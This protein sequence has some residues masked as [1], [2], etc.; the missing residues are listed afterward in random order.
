MRLSFKFRIIASLS[1]MMLLAVGSSAIGYYGVSR[2]SDSSTKLASSAME[3]LRLSVEI[4]AHISEVEGQVQV[5]LDDGTAFSDSNRTAAAFDSVDEGLRE[6]ETSHRQLREVLSE[7]Y[8]QLDAVFARNWAEII[9]FERSLREAARSRSNLAGQRLFSTEGKEAYDAVSSQLT[10]TAQTAVEMNAT[11]EMMVALALASSNLSGIR[12]A[13][14]A[15]SLSVDDAEIE[16]YALQI[17]ALRAEFMSQ[18]TTAKSEAVATTMAAIDAIEPLW[19][20]YVDVVEQ[21]T[22]ALKTNDK[23]QVLAMLGKKSEL[24]SAAHRAMSSIIDRSEVDF[25]KSLEASERGS[26]AAERTMLGTAIAALLAGLLLA[27][28][29]ARSLSLGLSKAVEVARVVSAGQ[30]DIDPSTSR[31]DEIGTLLNSLAKMVENLRRN[32]NVIGAISG[33]NLQVEFKAVSAEDQV[34]SSVERMVAQLQ[35]VIGRV[36]GDSESV[37]HSA[38]QMNITVDKLSDGARQQ[39]MAAQQAAAAI[40]E[41]TANISTSADNALQTE[42]MATQSAGEA[43]K[44][45]ETVEKA[46]EAMKT[47]AEKITI[48]QEIA[49]QTDLLALN[50]AVEAARAGEHG[51]GFAVV[52]S[53]VRKL[54]ERSQEAAQ[55]I[56]AL[57]QETVSVSTDAGR[58]LQQLVPNIQRTADL[59]QE[60]SASAREQNIGAEQINQ[61]IRDLDSAIQNNAAAADEAAETSDKLASRA[62]RLGEAVGHFKTN[63]NDKRVEVSAAMAGSIH[64]LSGPPAVQSQPP[65]KAEAKIAKSTP[66]PVR[67]AAMPDAKAASSTVSATSKSAS[68]DPKTDPVSTGPVSSGQT[69][70]QTHATSNTQADLNVGAGEVE[71]LGGFELDLGVDEISD[72]E[73]QAYQG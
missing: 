7:D 11:G 6:I 1:I 29:L 50:A 65:A 37:S 17:A 22:Q 14:A 38:Q 12:D 36:Q 56:G 31:K 46:V 18:I 52:A 43:Q 41:M 49:R 53:E 67:D 27:V 39:A 4:A 69:Q 19:T 40:E 54:A 16:H 32:Q 68:T 28:L 57:S 23:G 10:T 9:A 71:D 3:Q 35:S 21:V 64:E 20:S 61:A 13:E 72:D 59:V 8:A 60:I 70:L 24:F 47:I 34:G 30:L 44:S 45:G 51:K 5:Y 58:M 66:K 62:V 42:K 15:M 25:N 48:V 55:E 2:V 63:R 73:F 26:Q 33:G